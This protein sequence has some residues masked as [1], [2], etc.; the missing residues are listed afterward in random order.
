MKRRK[1]QKRDLPQVTHSWKY[2]CPI[3]GCGGGGQALHALSRHL[4]KGHSIHAPNT[5]RRL[6]RLV[7]SGHRMPLSPQ[8]WVDLKGKLQPEQKGTI[9][10]TVPAAEAPKPPM[11]C[12]LAGCPCQCRTT[13]GLGRHLVAEH[14]LY[15]ESLRRKL[16]QAAQRGMKVSPDFREL[17]KLD[18]P[19][20][21]PL[22][23]AMYQIAERAGQVAREALVREE[24]RKVFQTLDKAVRPDRRTDIELVEEI[25]DIGK[26][27]ELEFAAVMRAVKPRP[28]G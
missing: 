1:K 13:R 2:P 23:P 17:A 3:P 9:I 18:L 8:E 14:Q 21:P 26:L 10:Q 16:I 7:T 6:L 12:P 25:L 15:T 24:D 5:R 20:A 28:V 22:L 4:H 11:T 27:T 19:P